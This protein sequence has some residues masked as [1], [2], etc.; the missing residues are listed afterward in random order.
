VVLVHDVLLWGSRG[1]PENTLPETERRLAPAL[2]ALIARPGTSE[3][4][5]LYNAGAVLQVHI[6]AKYCTLL[7]T[8][9]AALV[10]HED[11]IAAAYLRSRDDVLGGRIGCVGLSGG[12]CRAALLLASDDSVGAAVIA[13]MM[14]SWPE[15]LDRHVA[16]H[17]WMF[18]PPGLSR[19]ADWP[20]VAACR[21]PAPLLVQYALDDVLFS[22]AGMRAAE[23][24]IAALYRDAGA[25]AGYR[26]EFY[27]GHH[28][29]DAALQAA[30]FDWLRGHLA[31]QTQ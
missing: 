9:I 15:L 14:S 30:A 17:S 5:A 18:F 8:S 25:P 13:G 3:Q 10:C 1:L 28:R 24:R 20:E 27:P 19:I 23:A 29:F 21:A 26:G 16:P 22:V 4:S 7:G 31:V 11:R 2:A 6:L 12:G